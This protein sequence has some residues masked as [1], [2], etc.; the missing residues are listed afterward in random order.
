LKPPTKTEIQLALTQ[1]KN[2]NAAVLDNINPE[3]LKVDLEI[4]G[5]ML[6][7]LLK[8]IP[9]GEKIPEEWEEGLIIKILEKGDL[10]NCNNWRGATLLSIPNKILT[11]VI[12][13][14]IQ[15]TVK[16]NT[17]ERTKWIP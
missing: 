1:F 2:G 8:K 10:S 11:R 6:Y 17:S 13:N 7:H 16:I 5:E 15:I 12:L 3:V 14:R 9:K 4:T